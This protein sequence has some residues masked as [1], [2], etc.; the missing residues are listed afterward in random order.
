MKPT[1]LAV[2][3]VGAEFGRR[4]WLSVL[5]VALIISVV[6]VV[7]TLLLTQL[8]SWWWLLGIPVVGWICVAGGVLTLLW[9]TLR[10]VT[11]P[12]TSPER[13]QVSQF[14]DKLQFVA[15]FQGTPKFIVLFRLMRSVAAPSSDRYLQ[16]ILE[17][18]QLGGEFKKIITIFKE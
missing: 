10:R 7:G 9:L 8:S 17:T 11:P 12:M 16:D 18:R 15:D 1:F 4:L 14:A 5:I 13:K 6:L 3:A 2:R